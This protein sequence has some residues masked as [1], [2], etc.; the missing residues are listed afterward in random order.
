MTYKN[1]EVEFGS[2]TIVKKCA[3]TNARVSKFV[4]SNTITLPVFMPVATYGAMRSVPIDQLSQDLGDIILSNTYHCRNFHKDIKK[5][6]NW[7]KSLLTDS[8]GF[9][10]QSL[11]CT[12][13]DE[14]VKFQVKSTDLNNIFTPED[15]MQ[16]QTELCSDIIMQLDDVVNPLEDKDIHS[17]A[18]NRSIKWL[19]RAIDYLASLENNNNN[20]QEKKCKKTKYQSLIFN[21]NCNQILFPIIQG[22]LNDDLRLKSITEILKR[23]PTGLAIGGMCGGED[24]D[25]FF[26]TVSFTTNTLRSKNYNGPIYLMGVG[27]PDDV[28]LCYGLGIDMTDCVYPTRIARRGVVLYDMGEIDLHRIKVTTSHITM[29]LSE[30]TSCNCELCS[31]S[32]YY[33]VSI[34]KTVNICNMVSVHNLKYMKKLTDRTK[35][36]INTNTFDQ[37]IKTYFTNKYKD[38]IPQWII[39]AMNMLKISIE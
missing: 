25:Q 1:K 21:I 5:F 24:K 19:D 39:N 10:I 4:L 17:V 18:V 22:G 3:F 23:N 38:K 6:M 20:I 2:F 13:V 12:I 34:K 8:G 26:K 29:L 31:Y 36:A 16:I 28:I 32:I 37:F 7:N 30:L 15:S 14:G 11:P 27:Y 35:D 33:L 9:Q